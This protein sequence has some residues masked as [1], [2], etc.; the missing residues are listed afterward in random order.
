M[1]YKFSLYDSLDLKKVYFE[2]MFAIT[3]YIQSSDI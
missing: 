2:F 3:P 1:F